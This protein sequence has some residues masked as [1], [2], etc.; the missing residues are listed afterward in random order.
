[1]LFISSE[2]D[3]FGRVE[4]R[5][6]KTPLAGWA[7]GARFGSEKAE[8]G[9][10]LVPLRGIQNGNR[11]HQEHDSDWNL[12]LMGHSPGGLESP[13]TQWGGDGSVSGS[14]VEHLRQ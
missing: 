1:M 8:A 11:D 4:E 14:V 10:S 12:G 9:C 5:K 3:A 13:R 2:W 6:E 7:I